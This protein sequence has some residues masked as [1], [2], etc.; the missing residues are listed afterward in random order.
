MNYAYERVDTDVQSQPVEP[1]QFFSDV[2][3]VGQ[4]GALPVAGLIWVGLG[5][6]AYLTLR[7]G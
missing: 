7:K 2:E 5:V 6:L 1:E 4:V 3:D